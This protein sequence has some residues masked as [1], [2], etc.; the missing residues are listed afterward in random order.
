[1]KGIIL[2]AGKGTRM[3]PATSVVNKNLIPILNIP[4]ITYSVEALVALGVDKIMIVASKNDLGPIA[5]YLG[6]GSDFGVN[7]NYSIQKEQKGISHAILVARDFIRENENFAVCL[8]DNIFDADF[9][10]NNFGNILSKN[11][12][13]THIFA[14]K[15]DDPKRFGVAVIENDKVT[16]VEEK[17]QNPKS[18]LA[19]TGLY[20]FPQSV[21]GIIDTL[22]PSARG[23][24]EVTDA[25]LDYVNN[26]LCTHHILDGFWSDAGTP[27][28]LLAVANHMFAKAKKSNI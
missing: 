12:G 10:K 11:D 4:L 27:E 9:I 20:I 2:A 16:G 19:V 14:K 15:V 25:I 3:L 7:F 21:F 13:N 1:M 18:D 17:P 8:A 24:Y 23:E 22:K 28:S 26:G 6:D 5:S